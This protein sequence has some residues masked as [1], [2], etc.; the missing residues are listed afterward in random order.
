[1]KSLVNSIVS[2]MPKINQVECYF[3]HLGRGVLKY[4]GMLWFR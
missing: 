4:K 1:M 2:K 3:C